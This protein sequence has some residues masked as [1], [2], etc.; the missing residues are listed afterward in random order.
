VTDNMIKKTARFY[1]PLLIILL[2]S[3]SMQDSDVELIR[4]GPRTVAVQLDQYQNIKYVSS[5]SGSD[6]QG[7]GS[8]Q[9]PW[10]TVIFALSRIS[11]ANEQNRYA[12]LVSAGSYGNRTIRMKE[13][14]DLYGGFNDKDWGRDI[15][16]NYTEFHGNEKRRIMFGADFSRVDGFVFREGTIRGKGAAIY[17]KG[18]SP[19]ITNNVFK[20]N[21]TLGPKPW[22]PKYRHE[23]TNDGGAVYFEY[24]S[25]PV[26]ENNLFID[27]STENGRGAALAFHSRCNG[28]ITNNVFLKNI[29]GLD[30]PLRSSDGGAVSVFDWS[31][32]LVENN[33]FLNNKALA[34]NDA[35][36]MFVALWSSPIIRKNIFVGNVCTDD[37]GALFVGGQEH[38]YDAPLDPLPPKD[39]FYIAVEEN[40]FIGNSNPSR[41]SGVTR[42]TMESRGVFRKNVT[43]Y[44]TGIY[45]QRSEVLIEDNL[46]LDHFRL[47]E[48]KK[49]LNPSVIRNNIIWG[50]FLI[51]TEADIHD[52]SIKGGYENNSNIP[53][54]L[55][56]DGF[57]VIPDAVYCPLRS[58]TTTLFLSNGTFPV[59][60][61]V[62]RVVKAGDKWSVIKSNDEKHVEVWGDFFQRIDFTILPTYRLK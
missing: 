9:S 47:V 62:N 44:N 48:T 33:L 15:D 50:D 24:G 39:Q 56:Q 13:Y 60:G 5:T 49:G 43:A 4:K 38:R 28:K 36:G 8:R 32:P 23:I 37:A 3:C 7:E 18:V 51:T 25:S 21:K 6:S 55:I 35:G 12:V 59:N 20:N 26:I 17:G 45:F 53:P 52:N 42:M 29:A 30:D 16:A 2:I 14:I 57:Q 10:E 11:D 31:S 1:L 41:N 40:L 22:N 58:Y 27:N 61:L 34:E 19:A 46:M 54:Q